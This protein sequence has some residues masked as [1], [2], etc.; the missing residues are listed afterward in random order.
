VSK[1]GGQGPF[2]ASD[3]PKAAETLREIAGRLVVA[4][5]SG[6]REVQRPHVWSSAGDYRALARAY[7]DGAEHDGWE[8]HAAVVRRFG[9]AVAR[10]AELAAAVGGTLIIGT[11]GLAA[12][13]WLASLLPV[14]PSP[15]QFWLGLRL[16][17]VVEVDLVAGT[18]S[19]P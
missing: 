3:E 2:V 13:V 8:A 6:F 17:D 1:I 12:T 4:T 9:D 11:H 5:D 16:L 19:R 14:R 18:A 10:H 15:A 7:V